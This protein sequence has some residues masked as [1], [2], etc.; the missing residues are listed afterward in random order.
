MEVALKFLSAIEIAQAW[1][2]KPMTEIAA[3]AG[4]DEAYLELYGRYKAKVDYRCL[5][6]TS[7][8]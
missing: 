2:M 8:G 6:Y 1:G 7:R 5:L 3:S 4:I